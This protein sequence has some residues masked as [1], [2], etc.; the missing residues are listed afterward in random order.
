MIKFIYS[1]TPAKTSSYILGH[2]GVVVD[3]HICRCK[4][5]IRDHHSSN[6]EM[7]K[8]LSRP[9]AAC[10]VS[11]QLLH[12]LLGVGGAPGHRRRRVLEQRTERRGR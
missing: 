3:M 1:N 2:N 9:H 4:D 5:I 7:M 12:H 11:F 6:V 8:A 10:A